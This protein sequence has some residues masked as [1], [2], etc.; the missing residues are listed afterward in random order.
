M[1]T[2]GVNQWDDNRCVSPKLQTQ[3]VYFCLWFSES[4]DYKWTN[5]FTPEADH[6]RIFF[7]VM[8]CNGLTDSNLASIN[9]SA[10]IGSNFRWSI[11]IVELLVEAEEDGYVVAILA[12]GKEQVYDI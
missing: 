2:K 5:L 8:H 6:G 9:N 11:C 7:N 4:E 12:I 10:K 3:A 1:M